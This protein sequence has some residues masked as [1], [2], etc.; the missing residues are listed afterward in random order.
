M[1]IQPMKQT[2]LKY[3][4]CGHCSETKTREKRQEVTD[5]RFKGDDREQELVKGTERK[6]EGGC[7]SKHKKETMNKRKGKSKG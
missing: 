7:G 5:F 4:C 3:V 6:G 2:D 1:N